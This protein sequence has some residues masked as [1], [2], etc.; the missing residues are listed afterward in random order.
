MISRILLTKLVR[1]K[2]VNRSRTCRALGFQFLFL[3]TVVK[4]I[5]LDP[6]SEHIKRLFNIELK[7]TFLLKGDP[8]SHYTFII[9][10]P[11][12]ALS[13]LE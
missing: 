6:P 2:Y 3:C 1:T 10:W 7:T 9:M 4:A 8:D 5:F 12:R 13:H 11:V